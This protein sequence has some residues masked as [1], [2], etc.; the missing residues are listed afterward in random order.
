MIDGK[1]I[2]KKEKNGQI[3]G[4]ISSRLMFLS[5]TLELIITKLCTKFQ[6]PMSS[7]SREICDRLN[8]SYALHRSERWKKKKWK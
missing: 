8:F 3:K 5:Y 7:S 4:M 1:I 6:N 2:R